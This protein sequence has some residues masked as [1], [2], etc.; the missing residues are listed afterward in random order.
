MKVISTHF[1]YIR[2]KHSVE[3]ARG[4]ALDDDTYAVEYGDGY[5]HLSKE[6]FDELD[7]T[8]ILAEGF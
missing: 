8:G 7:K 6:Q 5:I 3:F 2:S 4:Y 1:I